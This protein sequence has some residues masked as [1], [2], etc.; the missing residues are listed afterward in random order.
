M[1]VDWGK[2]GLEGKPA[3]LINLMRKRG[4]DMP[5]VILVRRKR[6]EDIPVEVLDFIDGYVFLAGIPRIH[7]QK[8]RQ[9]LEAICRD[10]EDALFRRPRR[11]CRGRGSELRTC[12][13]HNGGVLYSRSP[14]GRIFLEHLGEAIF[15]EL[16]VVPEKNDLNSLLFL[17]TPG[18]EFSKAGTLVS[19]LVAFKRLHDDNAP[20]EDVMPEFVALRPPAIEVCASGIFAPTCM[21]FS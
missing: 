17:L 13:G 20:L 11:L 5:I 14:I 7:R 16:R 8:S 6:F 2:K 21:F 1:V 4:L 3:S 19:A 15:R 18:V 12:P 10:P 9:P